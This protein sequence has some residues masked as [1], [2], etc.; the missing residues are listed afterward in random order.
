MNVGKVGAEVRNGLLTHWR[1]DYVVFMKS[2]Q[3]PVQV[4]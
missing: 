3:H 1:V 4:L 2:L